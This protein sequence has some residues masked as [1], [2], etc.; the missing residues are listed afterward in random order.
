MSI[1]PETRRHVVTCWLSV[2]RLVA[3]SCLTVH[4]IMFG[5]SPGLVGAIIAGASAWCVW[6]AVLA[7]V[8]NIGRTS[9]GLAAGALVM[10]LAHVLLSPQASATMGSMPMA[11][12]SMSMGGGHPMGSL[13]LVGVALAGSQL[14]LSGCGGALRLLRTRNDGY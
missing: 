4:A 7:G 13:M 14:I 2:V 8:E 12:G 1:S 6:H 3:V 11:M 9:A 5:R 10:L